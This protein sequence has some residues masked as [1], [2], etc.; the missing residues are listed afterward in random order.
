M[1]AWPSVLDTVAR[2]ALHCFFIKSAFV[3]AEC[4]SL[5]D[6]SGLPF[7]SYRQNQTALLSQWTFGKWSRHSLSPQRHSQLPLSCWEK[8]TTEQF[9][10]GVCLFVEV[11]SFSLQFLIKIC[12]VSKRVWVNCI[13]STQPNRRPWQFLT[14]YTGYPLCHCLHVYGVRICVS[15]GLESDNTQRL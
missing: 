8:G 13:I 7:L 14:G 6:K 4:C 11:S 15:S 10:P 5:Y 3:E 2:S 1:S 12:L 9:L